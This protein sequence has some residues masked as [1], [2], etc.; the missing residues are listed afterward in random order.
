MLLFYADTRI[1]EAKHG[2]ETKND[3]I[4]TASATQNDSERKKLPCVKILI[5]Q[6]GMC[7][8]KKI[9]ALHILIN[10]LFNF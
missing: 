4:C 10:F 8:T 6:S 5:G 3:I 9:T 7:K 1:R 2:R